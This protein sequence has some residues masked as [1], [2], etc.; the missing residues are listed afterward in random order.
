MSYITRDSGQRE[1]FASGMVR[2]L[3]QGKG[4]YDLV[5]P[6]GLKRIADV[7]ERGASKYA[8]RN[9]EKG[10]PLCRFFDSAM[11]HMQQW[12]KGENDEDHL[13]QAAWNLIAMMHLEETH[14]ELDDRPDWE[15]HRLEPERDEADD[16]EVSCGCCSQGDPCYLEREDTIDYRETGPIPLSWAVD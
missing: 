8:D 4:R 12:L 11:R 14:P 2:D 9:W 10:A 15:K 6:Y 3:R 13:A 1:H 5:S 7:Y 16:C